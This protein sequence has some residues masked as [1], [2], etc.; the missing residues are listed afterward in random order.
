MKARKPL[1][2]RFLAKVRKLPGGCWEWTA[3]TCKGYGAIKVE[4]KLMAAHRVAYELFRG[5]VPDGLHVLHDCDQPICVNPAHLFVGTHEQNMT[6]KTLKRRHS[7]GEKHGRAKLTERDI[8][9]I[10]SG[11]E[12]VHKT[13][14]QYGVHP[15]LISLIRKRKLWAHVP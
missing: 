8:R 11:N 1:E 7:F 10:R 13:A 3:C 2:Q 12:T 6:D 9:T 4:G 15:S 14:G 5:A